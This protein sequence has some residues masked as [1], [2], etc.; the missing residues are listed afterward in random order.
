MTHKDLEDCA[1]SS[2]CMS[3]YQLDREFGGIG[4]VRLPFGNIHGETLDWPTFRTSL[5]GGMRTWI[6]YPFPPDPRG[7]LIALELHGHGVAAFS[8]GPEVMD[9]ISVEEM[10]A[11]VVPDE[12]TL[13]WI[14]EHFVNETRTSHHVAYS[15]VFI[16][17]DPDT[18]FDVL[19]KRSGSLPREQC[20]AG[21]RNL[22]P[23]SIREVTSFTCDMQSVSCTL[24]SEF[25]SQVYQGEI[26]FPWDWGYGKVMP[27]LF[28]RTVGGH[29][30]EITPRFRAYTPFNN[31][32]FARWTGQQQ[33]IASVLIGTW[34]QKYPFWEPSL[35]LWA[36]AQV[37]QYTTSLRERARWD[38][39][40]NKEWQKERIGSFLSWTLC[41]DDPEDPRV[42]IYDSRVPCFLGAY[43][44]P[45]SCMDPIVML[46]DMI[47]RIKLVHAVV[48]GEWE[49]ESNGR[50]PYWFVDVI[51]RRV[52]TTIDDVSDSCIITDTMRL[53]Q[54]V[55]RFANYRPMPL[56]A[57][58]RT[59]E[60]FLD[61]G[62]R[63]ETPTSSDADPWSR[64]K[65][66]E[67]SLS[68]PRKSMGRI[69]ALAE[70]ER[71]RVSSMPSPAI[72]ALR[73][74]SWK[75]KLASWRGSTP[76]VAG[77]PQ[78]PASAA[79][80]V[81][82]VSARERMPSGIVSSEGNPSEREEGATAVSV[83]LSS[84]D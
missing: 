15:G 10:D 51:T 8:F 48:E 84:M 6:V 12:E 26:D 58:P 5:K 21:R 23:F 59:A 63:R 77:R 37:E 74:S 25:L 61:A 38:C 81:V 35:S 22:I 43:F 70:C 42:G 20:D 31:A 68:V 9:C 1:D 49:S 52:I 67:M 19:G 41:D 2:V 50:L 64:V 4:P 55:V 79:G 82:R 30:G 60:Y 45:Y 39:T 53:I 80:V 76:T 78:F 11:V 62:F 33:I 46:E 14:C 83:D 65:Q 54:D 57:Y 17:E 56:G 47:H 3:A 7:T 28:E 72:R 75:P 66:R 73:E 44:P 29:L 34:S 24:T 69:E 18:G 32:A 27:D 13:V 16:L 36:A 71:D 40:E